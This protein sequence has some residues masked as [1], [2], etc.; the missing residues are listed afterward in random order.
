MQKRVYRHA[1]QGARL[2]HTE[3][4]GK[5][6]LVRGVNARVAT[7]STPIAALVIAA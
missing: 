3:I 1:K 6:V 4:Q 5:S 7:I 2:G